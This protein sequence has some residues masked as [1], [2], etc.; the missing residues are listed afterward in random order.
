MLAQ[1]PAAFYPVG[2]NMTDT[3]A[4]IQGHLAQQRSVL[5]ARW[6]V[7]E[8]AETQL[9][10]MMQRYG[11]P[12]PVA[13]VLCQRGV[14]LEE[15]EGFLAPRLRDAMPDPF[16]FK[17][18]DRGVA[19]FLA[20]LERKE[21][22][23]IFGDYD[24][25]GATATAVLVRYMRVLGFDPLVHIPDRM[26][27]GYG[28]NA[29]ALLA[30][31][32]KGA[33]LVITVDCGTVNVEPVA[34]A[35]AAGLEV[36]VLDHHLSDGELPDAAAIINPNRA[37]ETSQYTYV[38]A[39]AM[40]FFFCAAVN[41]ALRGQGRSEVPDI[42]P[43]LD[44][45]ALGTVC[46]VM[47]LTGVNR[48]F[49]AQGLKILA[50]RRNVGMAALADV[51]G[52]NEA[53]GAYHLGFVYGPRI[54]AGGRVGEAGLGARLLTTDDPAEAS[55]LAAK[56]HRHNLERQ[57]VEQQVLL[58]AQAMAEAQ[59]E[60]AVIIVASEGWHPGVIG[61]VA[62]RLKELTRKPVAVIALEKGIG[63]ASA[64][65][66]AGVNLGAAIA[67]AKQEGLL[68]AGGGHAMAAGFTIEED[69]IP[70]LTKY[71]TD[72]LH[73][74]IEKSLS[75]QSIELSGIISPL[76]IAPALASVFEQLGPFGMGN[77]EPRLLVAHA[78]LLQPTI[79]KEQHIK[80][81]VASAGDA[82][83]SSWREAIEFRCVE[84]KLGQALLHAAAQRQPVHLA[85]R[86]QLN[87]WNGKE[88]AQLLIEDMMLA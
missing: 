57:A 23:A 74:F 39:A 86:I 28:L 45:V 1:R 63:K 32:D 62:G 31:R 37:D 17:D 8:A 49:V 75:E 36:I 53:P 27:E 61:I 68:L 34:I 38:C 3:Q 21:T 79:L 4:D 25:D 42:L 80:C 77:A 43:L 13:R 6:R 41:S 51:A 9:L 56:L 20:A 85:G 12:E 11:L 81:F 59:A 71:L 69:K 70:V 54:N 16:H 67:Q 52:L 72:R 82:P 47:K 44:L 29:D 58:E 88:K 19:R 60:Q 7:A 76:G 48:A 33:T 50:Q 15:V 2:M 24:V 30:L 66:V 5:G 78:I 22:I 40:A 10:A 14:G 35:K 64:R 18:M 65:S 83:R 26:L 46:D 87:S 73:K 84:T 55:V